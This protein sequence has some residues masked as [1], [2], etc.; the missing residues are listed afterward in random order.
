M[1]LETRYSQRNQV[2]SHSY[3]YAAAAAL[4]VS[5]DGNV[6]SAAVVP[7]GEYRVVSTTDCWI[8]EAATPVAAAATAGSMY[9]PANTP[10]F[11]QFGGA[12]KVA[13]IKHTAGTAGILSL[14]KTD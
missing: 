13:A 6:A 5:Y 1:G 14:V 11:I 3:N 8:T 10:V 7:A 2:T 4:V 9:L 12:T